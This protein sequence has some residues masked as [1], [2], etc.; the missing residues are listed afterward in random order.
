MKVLFLLFVFIL[1]FS[2]IAK[3]KKK[4][5]PKNLIDTC[6]EVTLRNICTKDYRPTYCTVIIKKKK[7]EGQGLNACLARLD[8]FK[9]L[10]HDHVD[11]VSEADLKCKDEK[12]KRK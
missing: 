9:E 2:A 6:N 12:V 8:L 7:Y 10:C 11:S 3:D 4:S 1:S 5:A